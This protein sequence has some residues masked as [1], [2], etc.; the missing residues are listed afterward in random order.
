MNGR[1]AESAEDTE[2]YKEMINSASPI[3]FTLCDLRVLCVSAV[4]SG[5]VIGR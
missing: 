2:K 1:D 4:I 3:L 5:F